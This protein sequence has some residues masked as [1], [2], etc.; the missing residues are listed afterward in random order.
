MSSPRP[1]RF[2]Q[3]LS[4]YC[5][6]RR[7]NRCRCAPD[8]THV[9]HMAVGRCVANLSMCA[10]KDLLPRSAT[11]AAPSQALPS[12]SAHRKLRLGLLAKTP[13]CAGAVHLCMCTGARKFGAV[14]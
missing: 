8:A 4:P 14:A 11:P 2:A 1:G 12:Y 5:A 3:V 9:R 10:C 6:D 7:L 13:W